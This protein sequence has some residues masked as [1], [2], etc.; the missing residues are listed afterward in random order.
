MPIPLASVGVI[1][2]GIV[3]SESWGLFSPSTISAMAIGAALIAIFVFRSRTHAAPLF[4]L[5]LFRLRSH[6]LGII[7]TTAF[8]VGFFAFSLHL[9]LTGEEPSLFLGVILPGVFLGAAAG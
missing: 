8:V 9:L 7:G 6:T 5:G 1:I 3:Q 4:D 2:L